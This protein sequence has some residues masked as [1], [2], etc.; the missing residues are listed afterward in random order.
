LPYVD[1]VALDVKTSL[2]K[3]KQLGAKD[4]SG[5]S[6]TVEMLKTGKVAYEFR[7]TVVPEFVTAEDLPRICEFV[8]GAKTHAFQQ[9]VPQDTLDKRFEDLKPYAPEIIEEF[10]GTMK[11]YAEN[12]I[13]RI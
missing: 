2:E 6:R 9:F 1:Y 5:L 10:A 11:N 8:K 7:T 13:L 3:Y 12:V 4:T